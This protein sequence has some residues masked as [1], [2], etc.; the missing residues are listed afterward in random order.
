MQ[1]IGM[2]G[3]AGCLMLAVSP[4]IEDTPVLAAALITAAQGFSA[5]TL[6]GVS[7]SHL[8]IAPRHAG[9]IFGFGNTFA[10][11]AGF[12]G[13][14]LTGEILE[15]TES[16]AVVFSVTAAHFVLGSVVWYIWVGD[17]Q[18]PEDAFE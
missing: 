3:P 2:L 12:L 4:S 1:I 6:A 5:L 16:W 17:E 13:T 9:A 7:V 10:T 11:V 8:D 18:L 14:K 15:V